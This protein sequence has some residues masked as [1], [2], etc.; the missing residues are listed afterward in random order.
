MFDKKN[1]AFMSPVRRERENGG[2][3]SL[4][5]NQG[6]VIV[7]S[8]KEESTTGEVFLSIYIDCSLRDICIKRVFA[9]NQSNST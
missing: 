7:P 4:K 6:Y 9:P 3:L 8:C 5:A 2:R 1:I